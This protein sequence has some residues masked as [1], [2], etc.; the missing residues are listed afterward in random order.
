MLAGKTRTT[1]FIVRLF[2]NGPTG[3]MGSAEISPNQSRILIYLGF[4]FAKQ[5]CLSELPPDL[6]ALR[7]RRWIEL[8]KPGFPT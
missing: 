6:G 3:K 2:E 7:A 5:D 1:L 8:N 4:G